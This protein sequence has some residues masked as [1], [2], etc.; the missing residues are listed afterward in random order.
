MSLSASERLQRF[1]VRVSLIDHLSF[2]LIHI[3][4]EDEELIEELDQVSSYIRYDIF[5]DAFLIH[6]LVLDY[7]RQKQDMLSEEEKRTTYLKAAYWCHKN[8]YLIDAITYYDKAG[9]YSEIVTLVYNHSQQ[10]P[11]ATAKFILDILDNVPPQEVDQILLFPVVHL[12]VKRS[13]DQLEESFELAS[14]YA[15]KYSALPETPFNNRVLCG[16]YAA[17]GI[18]RFLTAPYTD[19][20]DFDTYIAEL[21]KHYSRSPFEVTG[22]TIIQHVGPWISMVGTIREG[23]Q[24]EYIEALTR[25][26]PDAAYSMG[27]CMFGMDDLARGEL[28][29]YKN[30]MKAAECY[31]AKAL[32]SAR[33]NHQYD[34]KNRALFYMLRIGF[35]QG[36]SSKVEYAVSELKTQLEE[37]DYMIRYVSYDIVMAWYY[38]T[39]GQ[40]ARV[41]D[42]LKT[43]FELGTLTSFM[44]FF[45]DVIKRKYYYAEKDFNM[46]MMHIE[47]N[48]SATPIVFDKLEKKAVEAVCQYHLKN[49]DAALEAFQSAYEISRFDDLIMPFIE[50]GRDMRTLTAYA[51]RDKNCSIPR[52]WL[53]NINKKSSAYAKRLAVVVANY[54]QANNLNEEM[55][56]SERETGVLSDLCHGLSRSEI[57]ANSGLSINTIKRIV[58]TLHTK[59]GADNLAD[60]IRIATERKLV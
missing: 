49:K 24:N 60:I 6:H 29:F 55:Q 9:E 34:V 50:L 52:G 26:V 41:A 39:L 40:P 28:L 30:D 32:A 3:L 42:W 17:M 18:T 44:A 22:H 53:E 37:N 58:S 16:M 46:L 47:D 45:G 10:I 20:Y 7:L 31:V 15:K 5:M 54:K 19:C 27:G 57:A 1:L 4:A 23:A 38:S 43:D 35:A 56:L 59:L 25:M 21:R 33:E 12:R 36:N 13:L 11:V 48:K 14:C 8:G 2:D 51:M